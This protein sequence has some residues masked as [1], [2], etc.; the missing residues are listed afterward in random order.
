MPLNAVTTDSSRFLDRG[1]SGEHLARR[2]SIVREQQTEA[3]AHLR[4][5]RGFGSVCERAAGQRHQG[6]RGRPADQILEAFI[7]DYWQV[8]STAAY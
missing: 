2:P 3:G 8:L 5:V 7:S 4:A 6:K 1:V